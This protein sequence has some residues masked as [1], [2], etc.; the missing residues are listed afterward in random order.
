MSC[1]N[2]SKSRASILIAI[3]SVMVPIS[4]R[5]S[6]DAWDMPARRLFLLGSG[7]LF[8]QISQKKQLSIWHGGKAAHPYVK[9]VSRH[10]EPRSK[11]VWP[12]LLGGSF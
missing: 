8:Q 5:R 7:E 10:V 2:A 9:D 11:L 12:D 1:L 3:R 4:S 6:R